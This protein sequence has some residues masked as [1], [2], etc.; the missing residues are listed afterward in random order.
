MSHIYMIMTHISYPYLRIKLTMIQTTY[1]CIN[2]VE[3]T[4]MWTYRVP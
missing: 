4:T 3:Y 1:T 2:L